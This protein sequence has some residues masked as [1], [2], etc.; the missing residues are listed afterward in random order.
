MTIVHPLLEAKVKAAI[1]SAASGHLGRSWV[2]HS[3]TD[4]NDRASHPCGILHGEPF[5]VFAKLGLDGTAHERFQA[6]LSGL[7]LVREC[8]RIATPTPI[9]TGLVPLDGDC[10]L[11]TEALSERPPQARTRDDWR[12]IG[13]TLAA[14]HQ[15]HGE[16]FGLEAFNGFFGPLRQDNNPVTSNRWVDFYTERRVTPLLR[17][18][19]DSGHLPMDLAAGVERLMLRLPRICGPEP[20]PTLLHGDAQ[21]NNFV[22]TDTGAVV[23]D[24]APYFGHPEIDLALVDYFHPVPDEVFDAYRDVAPIQAGFAQRRDLWRVFVDLACVT[25]EA[26]PFV[27]DALA[28]LADTVRYYR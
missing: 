23:A 20:Q 18:A 15:V 6:E 12:S 26:T 4:L 8:A 24:V 5:S 22:T 10:L 19:S 1:E 28:R 3:F 9:A 16:R 25:V 14:L 11:M 27:P 17:S 21:Q 13:H 7:A 2:S